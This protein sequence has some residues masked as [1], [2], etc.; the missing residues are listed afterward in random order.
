MPLQRRLPKRGFKNVFKKEFQVVNL[1]SLASFGEG[2]VVDAETLARSG[3][4]RGADLPVKV[5]GG[6]EI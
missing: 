3:L 5:L 4:V 2:S 6:G 1:R